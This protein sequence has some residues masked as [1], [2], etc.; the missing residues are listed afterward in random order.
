MLIFIERE[1]IDKITIERLLQG[2]KGMKETEKKLKISLG[3]IVI[4]CLDA[5]VMAEF[6]TKLLGWEYTHPHANGWSAI[7][8]PTGQVFAFQE[9]SEYCSPTWPWEKGKPGQMIH[10]D[11]M[12]DNLEEG[13]A[14][15]LDCGATLAKEEYYDDSRTMFDPAGHPFCIDVVPNKESE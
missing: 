12:V 4:D 15:A 11:F 9:V 13:I 14:F 5:G 3:A 10:F 8:A 7:T 2:E 1:K 6:Y